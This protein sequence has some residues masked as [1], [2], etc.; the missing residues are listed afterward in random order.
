VNHGLRR[1]GEAYGP[2]G[3]EPSVDSLLVSG[4][5]TRAGADKTTRWVEAYDP[6]RYVHYEGGQDN[7]DGRGLNRIPDVPFVDIVNRTYQDAETIVG[8][9]TDPR[10]TRPVMRCEYAHAMGEARGRRHRD[11][12]RRPPGDVLGLP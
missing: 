3:Q 4:W 11:S 2:A 1:A 6:S 9:A 5:A 10:E 12:D 7:D 8:W